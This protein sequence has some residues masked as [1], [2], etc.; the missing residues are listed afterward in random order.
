MIGLT[1]FG[2]SFSGEAVDQLVG[3]HVAELL[4]RLRNLLRRD[5]HS[6][7]SSVTLRVLDLERQAAGRLV[8]DELE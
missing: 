8:T 4:A 3:T 7:Q 1:I 2:R 5:L 6:V